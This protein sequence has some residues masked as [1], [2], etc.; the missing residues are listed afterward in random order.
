[1]AA[2]NDHTGKMI[3]T[4]VRKT[5]DDYLAGWERIFGTKAELPTATSREQLCRCPA[6]ELMRENQAHWR[7]LRGRT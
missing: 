3:T 7:K 5:S 1:M 6:C 4:A 2:N